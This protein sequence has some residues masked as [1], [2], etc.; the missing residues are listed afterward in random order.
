MSLVANHAD[1]F[2]WL[3]VAL[4]VMVVILLL[5]GTMA[6]WDHMPK[7]FKRAMPWVIGTYVVIAYGSGEIAAS[8]TPVDP[9]I[10]VLLM[11]LILLG[12]VGTLLFGL[13]AEDYDE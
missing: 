4:A 6:R 7:R 12:L 11:L 1:L 5:M 10:R 13:T 3:N 9:G 2:R 8:S